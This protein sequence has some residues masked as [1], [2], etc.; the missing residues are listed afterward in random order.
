M[1]QDLQLAR[2]VARHFNDMQGLRA[3]LVGACLTVVCASYLGT[4]DD[5]V[6]ALGTVLMFIVTIP[7]MMAL[8]GYYA[9]NFGRTSGRGAQRRS[10]MLGASIGI[11]GVLDS[12]LPGAP[13]VL[14]CVWSI[15]PAWILWDCWPLRRYHVLTLTAALFLAVTHIQVPRTL[16]VYT[17]WAQGLLLLG[18]S[19]VVTGLADHA[20]LVRV[21]RHR[22]LSV[23]QPQ[24]DR[25]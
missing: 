4:R 14:W 19:A 16:D 23:P 11:L 10:A 1:E 6:G 15:W 25:S 5:R 21:M 13:S 7:G 9:S 17:W 24:S 3:V 12:N 18:F 22:P 2:V 20:L 8:D